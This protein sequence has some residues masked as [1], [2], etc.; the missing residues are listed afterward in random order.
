M[1]I[2][3]PFPLLHST[4]YWTPYLLHSAPL[5]IA[6]PPYSLLHFNRGPTDSL[7]HSALL[8]TYYTPPHS[9]LRTALLHTHTRHL[10]TNVLSLSKKPCGTTI[11]NLISPNSS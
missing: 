8:P 1:D 5:P 3:P 7:S 6:L 4:P 9:L 11:A 2:T 10:V